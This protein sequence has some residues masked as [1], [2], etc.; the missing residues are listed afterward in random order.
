MLTPAERD[1]LA[2]VRR[3]Y[4][5]W[6]TEIDTASDS[7]AIRYDG[8]KVQG[9]NQADS[10]YE[11]AVRVGALVI[12]RDRVDRAL[13][14]VFITPEAVDKMRRVH[15]YGETWIINRHE[16]STTREILARALLE[17]FK[18]E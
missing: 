9:S 4:P 7:R 11:L 17:E 15:C 5:D 8:V 6:V 10:T 3:N 16:L 14:R 18:H 1:I 12:K 13:D 2:Y